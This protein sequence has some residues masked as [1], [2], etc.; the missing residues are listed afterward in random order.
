MALS[1]TIVFQNGVS[2]TYH[3]V[4]DVVIDNSSK[5]LKVSVLGYTNE[6]YRISEKDNL[7]NKTEYEN[8]LK[9]I[10]AENEKPEAERNVDLVINLS[11]R[12]N[13]LVNQFVNELNLSVTTTEFEYSG[14]TDISLTNIYQLLS[15]EIIFQGSVEI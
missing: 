5:K 4:G 2:I 12:A 15:Q 6:Q 1:K 13:E 14:V 9:T 10:M 7:A 11:N 3:R 8:C